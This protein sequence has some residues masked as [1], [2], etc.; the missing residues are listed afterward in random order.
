LSSIAP[1]LEDVKKR[2]DF[3]HG[4]SAY[5]G[6]GGGKG[7]GPRKEKL[8]NILYEKQNTNFSREKKCWRGVKQLRPH[9]KRI[10]QRKFCLWIDKAP[11]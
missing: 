8:G 4:W 10:N 7:E 5:S 2:K 6:G 3:G 11:S 1:L 9:E